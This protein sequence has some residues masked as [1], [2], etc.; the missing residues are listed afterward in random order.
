M[1]FAR[2]YFLN[3]IRAAFDVEYW[4]VGPIVGY[5]MDYDGDLHGLAYTRVSSLVTLWRKLRLEARP[6]VVFAAQ[7]TRSL[8]SW[9]IYLLLKGFRAKTVFFGRGY[10]P[11][12]KSLDSGIVHYVRRFIR[13]R[14]RWSMLSSL[15]GAA[16]YKLLPAVHKYD[17]VFVAG[18]FAERSH[19]ND[20]DKLSRVNHFDLDWAL[21]DLPPPDGLPAR[22]AVFID[23]FL[24]YH[25]DMTT[26]GA[27]AVRADLYY[28]CL[29]AFFDHFEHVHGLPVIVA[30]HPK[31]TA[32][33]SPYG[34]RPVFH[35]AS[36]ALIKRSAMVFAHVSTAIAFAVI[37]QRPLCLIYNEQTLQIHPNQYDPMVRTAEILGCPL[38]NI[39]DNRDA[40]RVEFRVDI[41]RYQDYLNE[42]LSAKGVDVR[43]SAEIVMADIVHLASAGAGGGA[44]I[45]HVA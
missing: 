42:F 43:N 14:N 37:H 19:A 3:E 33:Y 13:T 26:F 36:N 15:A 38:L 24:P 10:L 21:A 16:I 17:V 44:G 6:G 31:A 7:V 34:G 2:R 12:P 20:A 39:Q 29:N 27:N 23:E 1:D 32:G 5:D 25:P 41:G 35:D 18:A 8:R 9:P 4:D 28:G 45:A 30:A 40:D 11:V 22:Y